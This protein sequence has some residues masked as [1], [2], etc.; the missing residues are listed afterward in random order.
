MVGNWRNSAAV[1]V[2]VY[3]SWMMSSKVAGVASGWKGLEGAIVMDCLR[4]ECVGV[5]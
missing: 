4:G 2:E 3:V 1:I 5:E